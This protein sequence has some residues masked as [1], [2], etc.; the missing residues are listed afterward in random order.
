V[1]FFVKLNHYPK[2]IVAGAMLGACVFL[3]PT[4]GEARHLG[5]NPDLETKVETQRTINIGES[6]SI[7]RQLPKTSTL[8]GRIDAILHPARD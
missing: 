2:Q 5:T 7:D 1:Y 6:R 8:E 3:L 4:A